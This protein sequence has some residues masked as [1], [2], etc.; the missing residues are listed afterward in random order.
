MPTFVYSEVGVVFSA[1]TTESN[2]L[3]SLKEV[4]M[5]CENMNKC[6]F[7]SKFNKGLDEHYQ[8][9]V[10]SYCHGILSDMCKR[11]EYETTE[12]GLAPENL[13]P[14]GYYSKRQIARHN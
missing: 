13:C 4:A 6:P 10:Q 9:M 8:V 5:G 11:K 2:P 1:P 7:F 3:T 14:S 12:G